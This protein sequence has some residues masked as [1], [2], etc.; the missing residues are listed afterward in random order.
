[1]IYVRITEN[2]V[3]NDTVVK[4]VFSTKTWVDKYACVYFEKW[5]NVGQEG[6]GVAEYQTPDINFPL[7]KHK[8]KLV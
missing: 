6:D 3:L 1:M 4:S 2:L 8:V 7:P 5:V